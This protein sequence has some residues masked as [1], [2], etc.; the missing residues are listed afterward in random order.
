MGG[1]IAIS[2]RKARGLDG[3]GSEAL[4]SYWWA[5]S[6]CA[7]DSRLLRPTMRGLLFL[8]IRMFSGGEDAAPPESRGCAKRKERRRFEPR[9]RGY[10]RRAKVLLSS[11]QLV[12]IRR[13]AD[14]PTYARILSAQIRRVTPDLLHRFYGAGL[15]GHVALL[16]GESPW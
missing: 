15:R 11:S 3:G 13:R 16:L 2:E 9:R 10:F 12:S 7:R 4:S 1:A 5:C 14:T 6:G 8:Q